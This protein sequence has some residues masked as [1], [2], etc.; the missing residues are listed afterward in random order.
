MTQV[1]TA[2]VSGAALGIVPTG[3]ID[4]FIPG[5]IQGL[6]EMSLATACKGNGGK[7]ISFDVR[8]DRRPDS[9][10]NA[11][12][13]GALSFEAIDN[14]LVK[15]GFGYFSDHLLPNDNVRANAK[16]L[17]TELQ[18]AFSADLERYARAQR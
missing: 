15:L 6:I 9:G 11:T 17:M 4:M 18:S 13:H 16:H 5:D 1:P 3:V 12:L 8:Y 14:F 2:A 7:G 10:S